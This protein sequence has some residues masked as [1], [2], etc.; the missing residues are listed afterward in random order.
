MTPNCLSRLNNGLD[1]QAYPGGFYVRTN[2]HIHTHKPTPES[3]S[4]PR[5]PSPRWARRRSKHVMML[6]LFPHL[7][8]ELGAG[9]RPPPQTLSPVIN[10]PRT[11]GGGMCECAGA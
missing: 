10:D 4:V 5:P 11:F 6:V 7:L 2:T 3:P 8:L 1:L 9:S